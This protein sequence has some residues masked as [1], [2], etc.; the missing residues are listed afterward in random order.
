M[1]INWVVM[2]GHCITGVN[3]YI[4]DMFLYRRHVF[5][6]T[7]ISCFQPLWW[8]C[9]IIFFTHF[10]S[11]L[12]IETHKFQVSNRYINVHNLSL[13]NLIPIIISA[14]KCSFLNARNSYIVLV[15]EVL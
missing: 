3:F 10:K 13:T 6:T 9:R 5:L 8:C 4:V 7:C 12:A 1:F 15:S 14:T 2:G 11:C